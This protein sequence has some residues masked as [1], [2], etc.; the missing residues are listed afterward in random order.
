LKIFKPT[1]WDKWGLLQ[2][3]T[4]RGAYV[5]GRSAGISAKKHRDT[6]LKETRPT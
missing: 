4:T 6:I 3:V 2:K 5:S 1:Q